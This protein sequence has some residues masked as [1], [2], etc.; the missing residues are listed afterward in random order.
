MNAE[1]LTEKSP[2][3]DLISVSKSF[4]DWNWLSESDSTFIRLSLLEVVLEAHSIIIAIWIFPG[5]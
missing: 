5:N 2:E 4:C 3:A 1:F